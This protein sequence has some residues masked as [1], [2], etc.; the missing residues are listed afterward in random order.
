MEI[1][2]Q[3]AL[4]RLHASTQ[5]R[6]DDVVVEV[7][8]SLEVTTLEAGSWPAGF[9]RELL[10]L[11]GDQSFLSL[12]NSWHLLYFINSNWE[13]LSARNVEQLIPALVVAYDKFE[14]WMGA[15]VSSEILGE[16]CEEG[17]ALAILTDLGKTARLPARTL[18]PH[19]LEVL[20]KAAKKEST[21]GLVITQ[22]QEL[23]KSES[24]EVRQEALIS[25]RA[26]GS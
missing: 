21:R 14:D 23:Q 19:G 11:L 2:F 9:S 26:L 4:D 5:S 17:A 13:Q 18:V 25:L 8:Q 3:S 20:A 10:D 6:D 15:F 24:E 12:K 16:R 7:L 22:L 1:K